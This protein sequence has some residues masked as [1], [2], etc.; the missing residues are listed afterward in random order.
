MLVGG[1][2][3]DELLMAVLRLRCAGS[4]LGSSVT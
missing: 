4:G 1:T 3:N 2:T